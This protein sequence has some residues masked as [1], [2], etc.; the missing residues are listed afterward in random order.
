V[1][2]NELRVISAIIKNQDIAP[3][4]HETEIDKLFVDYPDAWQFMKDYYYKYRSVV[5]ADIVKE[6]FPDINFV[7]TSGNVK[8]YLD[9]LRSEYQ[10]NMLKRILYGVGED[11]GKFPVEDL[12]NVA[13]AKLS[14]L[15]S[16]TNSIRDLDITDSE[17][18]NEHYEEKRRLMEENGGVLGVR[19]GFDSID[20]NYPT[21]M[22]SGQYIV[23]L[24]RTGQG[25]SWFALQIAITAWRQGK[26]V[27]Y[28]S[29]E[30]PPESVRD[31]AYTFMSEGMFGM[32]DLSR[33]QIDME[34]IK[35]WTKESF[36]SDGS[37]VVTASDGMGDFSPS[38]LQ[39]K[40]DQYAPDIVIVD[41]LQLMAD[42]R[43]SSGSTERVRNTSKE[44][45]SL[46]MTNSIPIVMV[47]AAS[48]NE[49]KEYNSPPQIYENAESKQA[50]FDVD[51]CLALISHKQNDG[52][53][54]MEMC[55]RKNR[56]GPDFN[57][58]IN[59]DIAGGKMQETFD[60]SLLDL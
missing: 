54:L 35:L 24:S 33:A 10:Q 4:L 32:S 41:Y 6:N 22:A 14:D 59:L 58:L 42:R 17:K 15:A 3:A 16:I 30:M 49:T 20:A 27:L 57:F 34:A 52:T 60:S 9:Q 51:L 44:V 38:H 7:E 29:L 1:L 26:K 47:A 13:S 40:I 43:N 25:K 36:N 37:F 39:A 21:G 55:C 31:R 45:K 5:P 28:V 23:I 56:H 8:H 2:V 18:A 19:T 53:L 48:V 12:I 50:V 11:L 46:A